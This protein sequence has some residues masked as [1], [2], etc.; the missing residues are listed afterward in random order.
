MDNNNEQAVAD[1]I[2]WVTLGGLQFASNELQN[3]DQVVTAAVTQCGNESQ[4]ASSELHNNKQVVIA[5]V[6]QE[7]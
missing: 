1:A 4:Y 6:A 2:A 3:N 5:A 7:G